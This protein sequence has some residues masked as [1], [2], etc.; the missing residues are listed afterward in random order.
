[1][2]FWI[3]KCF[4][5]KTCIEKRKEKVVVTGAECVRF[6]TEPI[7]PKIEPKET[8]TAFVRAF[9]HSVRRV[10][11]FRCRT[12]FTRRQKHKGGLFRFR[13]PA[14]NRY[15]YDSEIAFYPFRRDVWV[16]HGTVVQGRK[17][18]VRGSRPR[19]VEKKKVSTAHVICVFPIDS[20]IMYQRR[21][22][23]FL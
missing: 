7:N 18:H 13:T 16:I 8:S 3:T 10:D 6:R 2:D 12:R 21:Y 15:K 17:L 23:F 11:Y 4:V 20:N 14:N 1:V 5:R 22:S 9:A 19:R